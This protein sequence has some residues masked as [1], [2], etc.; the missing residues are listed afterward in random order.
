MKKADNF[1]AS[2]WLTENKITTQSRLNEMATMIKKN[3]PFGSEKPLQVGDTIMW[4]TYSND[5]RGMG[6]SVSGRLI[7]K[8][9][10]ILGT[11]NL[12]A[13]DIKTGDLYKVSL[14]ELTRVPNVGDK[15][16]ATLS[17]NSGAGSGSQGSNKISGIVKKVN[18]EKFSMIIQTENSDKPTILDLKDL[19]DVKIYGLNESRLNEVT[20]N[21]ETGE[22]EE[23]SPKNK[24]FT[25][26]EL[27][28]FLQKGLQSDKNIKTQNQNKPPQE[29]DWFDLDMDFSDS[30]SINFGK[31][32][33]DIDKFKQGS[34]DG[35]VIDDDG[36]KRNI[37]K[38]TLKS[39]LQS[40]RE[41]W[42]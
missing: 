22:Y 18:P 20:Y 9:V 24:N 36:V 38:S 17:Y 15:I 3:S 12:Q 4:K 40:Y 10:K 37:D 16:E 32:E 26:K 30:D 28:N 2:K 39:I 34:K 29:T 5:D 41:N 25:P 8:V 11:A 27:S 35:Y 21:L 1:N 19:R 31:F 33:I 23:D 13:E 7:G 42:G 14:T 6:S